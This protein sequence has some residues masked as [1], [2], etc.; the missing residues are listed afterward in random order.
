MQRRQVLVGTIALAAVGALPNL[1]TLAETANRLGKVTRANHFYVGAWMKAHPDF[2]V[3]EGVFA[4]AGDVLHTING[5][6]LIDS[7]TAYHTNMERGID[8]L[9]IVETENRIS[10]TMPADDYVVFAAERMEA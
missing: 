6:L 10:V 5:N 7:E 9:L 4:Q 1:A 3:V 2:K 8:Q